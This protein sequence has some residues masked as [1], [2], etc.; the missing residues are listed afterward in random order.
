MHLRKERGSHPDSCEISCPHNWE[1]QLL[2][3][4]SS[5]KGQG[6][7]ALLFLLL[8]PN[9]GMQ[10][11]GSHH[12]PGVPPTQCQAVFK[13][14]CSGLLHNSIE[15]LLFLGLSEQQE[16]TNKEVLPWNLH[17]SPLPIPFPGV[18]V[19]FSKVV[20]PL[21][22]A[23]GGLRCR[24]GEGLQWNQSTCV[25]RSGLVNVM[26]LASEDGPPPAKYSCVN[27]NTHIF[28]WEKCQGDQW[29]KKCYQTNIVIIC[30]LYFI[31]I[32]GFMVNIKKQKK[33][34]NHIKPPPTVPDKYWASQLYFPFQIKI[35]KEDPS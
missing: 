11:E 21:Y 6:S 12:A 4:N 3:Y 14:A 17:S 9:E 19:K 5:S 2:S 34:L 1:T 29:L 18:L 25:D 26:S 13:R 28:F 10:G 27:T 22:L 30:E 20:L 31:G 16:G 7:S 32:R 8:S 23:A 35:F 33:K 15:V 24:G